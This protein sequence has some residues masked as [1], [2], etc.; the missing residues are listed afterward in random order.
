MVI[1]YQSVAK[2]GLF[3]AL[4]CTTSLLQTISTLNLISHADIAW[5]VEQYSI[6]YPH[7]RCSRTCGTVLMGILLLVHLV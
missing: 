4:Y 6:E 5:L 3:L 7:I 2:L 1:G